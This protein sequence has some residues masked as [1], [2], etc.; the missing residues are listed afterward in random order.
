MRGGMRKRDGMEWEG[1]EWITFVK[2]LGDGVRVEEV[3]R[4]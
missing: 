4:N 3:D 2:S 1:R